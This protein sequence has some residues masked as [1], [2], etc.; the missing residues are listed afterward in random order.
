MI[1]RPYQQEAVRAVY[2]HLREREGNPCVVLPTASGKTPLLA[3]ICKDAVV[4][5]N[6]RVLVLAHV[7]ELLEQAR[8]KL[9]QVAPELMLSIGLYSAGLGA[10]DADTPIVVAGVQSVFR[11]ATELG[12]FDLVIVD[13][14]H[15]IRPGKDDEGMYR[16]LLAGLKEVNP[17]LR[18]IGLT[19]TPFRM[20]SGSI[21]APE[22]ILNEVCYEVSVRELIAQGYLCPLVTKAGKEKADTSNLHVRAGE[23]MANEVEEL[24][25]TEALVESACREIREY[26]FDRK[27]CLVFASGIRHGRHVMETLR[28]MG[29]HAEAVFGETLAFERDRILDDF[30]AGRLKYLINVGVLTTG[31]DAPNID[32]VALL[33][34]T[35]S[36][37]LYY[38]MVGRGFRLHPGKENCLVLDFGE[39]IMRHGPVD[40]L[41]VEDGKSGTGEAPAKECPECHSVIAA[42]YM[43]CPD[44]GHEFERHATQHEATASKAGI[45]SGVVTE[46]T[47]PVLDVTYSIYAK[48]NASPGAPPTMRV[49]YQIGFRHWQS[50]WVCFQ[51]TGFARHKAE[52]WW[53]RRSNVTPVPA[54]VEE[55]VDLAHAGAL[56]ET[57]KITV[58]HV[59]GEKYDRIVAYELGMKP[60]YR[61]PGW[62]EIEMTAEPNTATEPV[63]F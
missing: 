11:R 60:N 38:Q 5:W 2:Q 40:M 8:D 14:A 49:D 15:T 41:Q 50:E 35:M 25:D 32:C 20:T 26:C 23:Y 27:S 31:F 61:E 7:R 10:R 63:P 12:H 53:R 29:A 58:R 28:D 43:T 1:L 6:G 44:C 47:H 42:G 13:E 17:K 4:E 39:N 19:A 56:C 9:L 21:C 3:Q 33:R 52:S 51:H 30:R 34:P 46:E 45:L 36:P 37:G 22:N 62:D 48:R 57:T 59:T 18:V 16:T 55:A 54:T 24:M